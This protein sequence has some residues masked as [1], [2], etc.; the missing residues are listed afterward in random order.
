MDALLGS[1]KC[2][3]SESL[4]GVRARGLF[5]M[6]SL[7]RDGWW[8]EKQRDRSGWW[9]VAAS[10]HICVIWSQCCVSCIRG[11]HR[12]L[13]QCSA[14]HIPKRSIATWT[15]WPGSGSW[16]TTHRPQACTAGPGVCQSGS[17]AGCAGTAHWHSDQA[18][19]TPPALGLIYVKAKACLAVPDTQLWGALLGLLKPLLA[20]TD[21]YWL[22]LL[23]TLCL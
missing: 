14:C 20:L 17:W 23:D 3:A 6:Q 22:K 11:G 21:T 4:L 12:D 18:V 7:G 10:K 1:G 13:S 15:C 5:E 2:L 16:I 19:C 9:T 8:C